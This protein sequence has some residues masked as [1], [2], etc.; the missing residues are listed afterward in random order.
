MLLVIDLVF[1]SINSLGM[2]DY[3][4][5]IVMGDNFVKCPFG[6]GVHLSLTG[7][8]AKFIPGSRFCI[9]LKSVK[10]SSL[11]PPNR[12]FQVVCLSHYYLGFCFLCLSMVL[13]LF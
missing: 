13:G 11:F 1:P 8:L 3:R 4:R 12:D 6:S 9:F 7:F 10:T 2:Q 5:R